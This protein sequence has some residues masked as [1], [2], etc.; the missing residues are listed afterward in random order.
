MV[1]PIS[2]ILALSERCCAMLPAGISH[3][4]ASRTFVTKS[5]SAGVTAPTPFPSDSWVSGGTGGAVGTACAGAAGASRATR[6]IAEMPTTHCCARR[7]GRVA[8]IF[9]HFHDEGMSSSTGSAPCGENRIAVGDDN[10]MPH[11]D[12]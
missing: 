11:D 5:R 9:G 1:L 6:T 10:A 8:I 7:D 2:L 12:K 4:P 3:R